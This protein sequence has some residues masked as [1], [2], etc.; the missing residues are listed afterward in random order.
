M[1]P[2]AL[3]SKVL[4]LGAA[5]GVRASSSLLVVALLARFGW[6]ELPQ[7]LSWLR[8]AVAIGALLG[9]TVLEAAAERDDDVQQVLEHLQYGLRALAGAAVAVVVLASGSQ[10]PGEL[11]LAAAGLVAAG[12]AVATHG[13]RMRLHRALYVVQS[14]AF[15][16]RKWVNRLEDGGVIGVAV[17]AVLAPLVALGVVAAGLCATLLGAWLAHQVEA[18]WRRPCPACARPI[19]VEASR[20]PSCRADVP[21]VEMK[22]PRLLGVVRRALEARRS[23]VEPDSA[24]AK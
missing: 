12:T 8:S 16:P 9:V 10:A 14:D 18:W 4:G 1:I 24:A 22:D 19:R 17:A 6:L 20:C 5:S 23:K 2:F 11:H 13:L 3:A 15:H 21:V 7:Q